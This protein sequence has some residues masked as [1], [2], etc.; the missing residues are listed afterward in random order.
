[1]KI[2]EGAGGLLL[3]AAAQETGLLTDLTQALGSCEPTGPN[4]SRRPSVL[5]RPACGKLT[6]RATRLPVSPLMDTASRSL[7]MV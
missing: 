7:P 6:T 1:M 3:L 5:G 2:Q 4:R